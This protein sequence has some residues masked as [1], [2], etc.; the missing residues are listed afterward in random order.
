VR[1]EAFKGESL[2]ER[3]RRNLAILEAIRRS[4]PISKTD[5][6]KIVG[7]NVATVSNY[8]EEFLGK[9]L[10]LEKTL[11]I[12]AGGRRPLLLDLNPTQTVAIGVGLNLL[13]MVGVITDLNGKLLYCIKRKKPELNINDIVDSILKIT[14]ELLA[15]ANIETKK[16]GGIGVGIAGVLDKEGETISWPRKTP[17]GRTDYVT[18]YLPLRDS[19]ERRFGLNAFIDNDA[20]LACFGEQWLTLN[21]DIEHLLYLFSGVGC[22]I[23]VDGQ[24]YRGASGGAGEI[25]IA[26]PREDGLFNCAF[27][28][29]CLMKRT[30]ADLGLVQTAKNILS[31][32]SNLCNTSLIYKLAEGDIS[33]V[34]LAIIFKAAAQRDKLAV[35][36][37]SAAAKRLAIKIAF[38]ANV[39]NPQLIIIGGGLEE[40]G[41]IFLDIIRSAINEWC[42]KQVAQAAKI[43]PSRL[44]ENAVAMGAASLVVRNIFVKA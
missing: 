8:I 27:G 6:S 12:S 3:A 19:V 9:N 40:A 32:D 25:S 33:K 34:D 5:I 44:G 30:E 42:F 31:Q 37:V 22:G 24:I 16:V 38:L 43:I 2:T 1:Q 26:N 41:S 23:M 28:N 10:V 13:H 20:T 17:E 11:D 29:P 18:V 21:A 36:I 7:L 15:E 35:E 14:E 39:F 4:G